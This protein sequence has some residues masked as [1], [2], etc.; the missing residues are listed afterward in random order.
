MLQNIIP[1]I[2]WLR[3]YRRSDFKNDLTAGIIVA[4]LLIPQ[5]MAYVMLAGF[6]HESRVGKEVWKTVS[7]SFD[8]ACLKRNG[9]DVKVQ[10]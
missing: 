4:V 6:S 2:G 3:D 10:V 9:I 8:Q 5:G 1:A 7:I